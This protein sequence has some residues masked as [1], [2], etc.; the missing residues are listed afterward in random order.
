MNSC[1]I[2]QNTS[3]NTAAE[4]A[5]Q[6]AKE[7]ANLAL[8]YNS[9]RSKE[10]TLH[11]RDEVLNIYPGVI[12]SVHAG[13][14]STAAAVDALFSDVLS[15]H[16]KIDIVVNTAGIVLKKPITTI[17]EAEYDKVSLQNIFNI[18]NNTMPH[19]VSLRHGWIVC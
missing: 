12:V 10:S 4:S 15:E 7:G 3:A 2:D 11:F 16:K 13:D 1:D 17:S 19:T 9:S 6:L 8:H 5:R 18:R 14:L